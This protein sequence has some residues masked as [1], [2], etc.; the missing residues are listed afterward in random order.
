[1]QTGEWHR[2][3]LGTRLAA[4]AVSLVL[5]G[6]VLFVLRGSPN[7]SA[8]Q[9]PPARVLVR[10]WLPP[11]TTPRPQAQSPPRTAANPRLPRRA[12]PAEPAR[13]EA[14]N[15][16]RA[17]ANPPIAAQA[18]AASSPASAALRL[19]GNV[20]RRAALVSEGTIR[21]MARNSGTELDSP[22]PDKAA[23]LAAA[24]A[25]TAI[26]DC[27]APNAGGSLLSIPLIAVAA[28]RGQCK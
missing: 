11:R 18:L 10:L 1:M 3:A 6:G 28:I 17:S 26:P 21:R 8:T 4:G 19:D 14:P 22:R 12:E 15:I 24:V 9:R 25:E 5:V 20:L 16:Q 2:P 13:I 7:T 27:L 23:R